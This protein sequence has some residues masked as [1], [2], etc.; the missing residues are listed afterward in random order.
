MRAC[1]H[2][3]MCGSTH[4]FDLKQVQL[5]LGAAGGKDPKTVWQR[6]LL[7]DKAALNHTRTRT[8]ARTHTH[9]HTHMHATHAFA[10]PLACA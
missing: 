3:Y 2:A 1:M 10:H 5:R 8:H 7:E 6:Q 4:K 9:T